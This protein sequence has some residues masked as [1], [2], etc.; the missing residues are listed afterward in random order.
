MSDDKRKLQ[1]DF[2]PEAV[3]EIDELQR[4]TRLA[5]RVEV[6]RHATRLFQWI[7][8]E[9]QK[10][11]NLCIERNGTVRELIMFWEQTSESVKPPNQKVREKYFAMAEEVSEF[12]N[13]HD[14]KPQE[15]K[16]VHTGCSKPFIIFY[17]SK[18]ELK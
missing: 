16:I 2:T 10:G 15:I 4:L 5:T 3:E 7:V 17:N 6:I 13:R 9:I 1:F 11:G 12:M 8:N 14:L 18:D